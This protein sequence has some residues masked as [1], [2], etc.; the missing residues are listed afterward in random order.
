MTP[1]RCKVE[2]ITSRALT[3]KAKDFFSRVFH[4]T[5]L[6]RRQLLAIQRDR[7]RCISS[8]TES[9]WLLNI[10]LK[11]HIV[12]FLYICWPR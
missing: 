12:L 10:D 8:E 7:S 9:Q 5:A 2:Q 11:T 3:V 4:Q 6:T 1:R